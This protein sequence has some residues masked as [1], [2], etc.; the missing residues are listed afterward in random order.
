MN[1]AD[2]ENNNGRVGG[3]YFSTFHGG[4]TP[5]W[6]PDTTCYVQ[7]DGIVAADNRVGLYGTNPALLRL[8]TMELPTGYAELPY[9]AELDAVRGGTPPYEWSITGGDLPQGLFLSIDN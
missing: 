9:R 8:G 7:F 4:N 3:I 1:F 5:D 2:V 6:G